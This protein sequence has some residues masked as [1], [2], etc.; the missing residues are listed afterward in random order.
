MF[1]KLGLSGNSVNPRYTPGRELE[2]PRENSDDIYPKFF[3]V[4]PTLIRY[5]EIPFPKSSR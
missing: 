2:E 5:K 1:S 3:M 4:S